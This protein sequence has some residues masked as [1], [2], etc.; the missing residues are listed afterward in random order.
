MCFPAVTEPVGTALVL[1]FQCASYMR[2]P[3][4]SLSACSM[5]HPPELWDAAWLYRWR[6]VVADGWTQ[7]Y[8]QGANVIQ[9][10]VLPRL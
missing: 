9:A 6:V 3:S 8:S 10:D 2:A 7:R 1:Y 4:T 5:R